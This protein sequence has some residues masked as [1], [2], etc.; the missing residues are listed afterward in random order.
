M[1]SLDQDLP[2][3]VGSECPKVKISSGIEDTG[4]EGD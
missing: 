2:C 1:P 4:A 3:L